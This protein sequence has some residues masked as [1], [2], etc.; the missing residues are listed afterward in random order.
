ML[1][2]QLRSASV[3][4]ATGPGEV[5]AEAVGRAQA[6]AL[7]DEDRRRDRRQ[8]ARRSRRRARPG[9]D[10]RRRRRDPPTVAAAGGERSSERT[11]WRSHGQRRE[12]VGDD[13]H[14]VVRRRSSRV[15]RDASL[16]AEAAAEVGALEVRARSGAALRSLSTSPAGVRGAR[17]RA[18]RR[19]A[20][21]APRRGRGRA[22]AG[23]RAAARSAAAAGAAERDAGRG[24]AAQPPPGIGDGWQCRL[25]HAIRHGK[26]EQRAVRRSP[27]RSRV[28]ASR[29]PMRLQPGLE[30]RRGPQPE[31]CAQVERVVER[32]ALVVQ[33]HVVGARHAHDVGAR[34]RRR[35]A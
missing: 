6:G 19:R 32:R 18:R 8:S 1:E 10:E 2:M 29:I 27:E 30:L 35:A 22:R 17:R 25:R 4:P 21:D 9:P 16:V 15:Q 5:D 13:E 12:P 23:S 31:R 7:A 24:E 34:P 33:H 14:D 26:C 11:A 20:R 3:R 28:P